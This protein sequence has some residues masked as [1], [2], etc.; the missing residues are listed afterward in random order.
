[1]GHLNPG[2]LQGTLGTELLGQRVNL[3]I[4]NDADSVSLST[5]I[6]WNL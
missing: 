5:Q 2:S 1:M 6:M 3:N 4:S